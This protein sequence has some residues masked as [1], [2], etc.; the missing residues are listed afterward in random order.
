MV[1]VSVVVLCVCVCVFMCFISCMLAFCLFDSA[2]FGSVP[3]SLFVFSFLA[4]FLLS[5]FWLLGL[6]YCSFLVIF[7]KQFPKYIFK[8][9]KLQN[10]LNSEI[11]IVVPF[12]Y[13]NWRIRRFL[14]E[15]I[16]DFFCYVFG[17][18]LFWSLSVFLCFWFVLLQLFVF[19][20]TSA[21]PAKTF[22]QF[23]RCNSNPSLEGF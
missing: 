16:S 15:D 2:W 11:I 8:K 3:S 21:F 23:R 1:I 5:F 18:I 10:I 19:R 4:S 13:A 7:L 6:S 14:F 17:H 9:N 20:T 12:T 22:Q